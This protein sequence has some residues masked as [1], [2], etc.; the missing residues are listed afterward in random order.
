MTVKEPACACIAQGGL[1]NHS[2]TNDEA[3]EPGPSFGFLPMI[4]LLRVSRQVQEVVG[5]A[6]V[7]SR[8]YTIYTRGETDYQGKSCR[9]F[10]SPADILGSYRIYLKTWHSKAKNASAISGGTC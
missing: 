7:D 4:E 3:S 6:N 1:A 10:L 8:M 5:K 2:R 9:F